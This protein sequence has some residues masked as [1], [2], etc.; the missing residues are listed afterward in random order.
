[1]TNKEKKEHAEYLVMRT[2]ATQ[3]EIAQRV[4]V[5]PKTMGN[6][7]R[8]ND[9]DRLRTSF[10]IT[11]GQELQ[12]IYVQI[13]KLNDTIAK[14]EESWA[15]SKEADTL[16]KLAATA[17]SLETETSLADIIDVAIKFTD[18]LREVDF[19]KSKEVS[20]YFDSFIKDIG[21]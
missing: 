13:S 12:R 4:G 11:K 20:D 6:W 7:W 3:K 19:E 21:K 9:W 15:T 5:T 2:N 10:F 16:S 1:M 17:R 8:D 18:W 14:R